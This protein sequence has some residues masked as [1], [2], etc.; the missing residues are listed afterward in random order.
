MHENKINEINLRQLRF[1]SMECAFA[2]LHKLIHEQMIKVMD[3][4]MLEIN[5]K[6]FENESADS[7]K[8]QMKTEKFRNK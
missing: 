4:S 8:Y 6:I 2:I 7:I 3:G 1:R 5:D